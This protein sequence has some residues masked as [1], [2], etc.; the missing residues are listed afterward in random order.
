MDAEALEIAVKVHDH[1]RIRQ[2]PQLNVTQADCSDLFP[3]DDPQL[4]LVNTSCEHFVNLEW[5]KKIP[6]SCL[7]ALQ[8][9]DMVHEQHVACPTS[10]EDWRQSLGVIDDLGYSG[11]RRTVYDK[12][13][14]NRYMLIGRKRS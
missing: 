10:L 7:F 4:I 11:V 1:W 13:S 8:S 14:F 5:W 3:P 2:Y 6:G 9:T 12:F